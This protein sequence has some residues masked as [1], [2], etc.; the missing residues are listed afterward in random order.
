MNRSLLTDPHQR[1]L[2]K[3]WAPIL[4]SGKQI[5]SETTKIALAQLL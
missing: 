1:R 2:L 3:K 5:E 4:E